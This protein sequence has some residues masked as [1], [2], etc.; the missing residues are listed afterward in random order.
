[1][2]MDFEIWASDSGNMLLS[3]PD[4]DEA[5]AW[6]LSYWRRYGNEAFSALS[7]GDEQNQW[8]VSG[9]DLRNLLWT[10]LW[11]VRAPWVTSASDRV[12]NVRVRAPWVTSASDR[13]VNI[14]ELQPIPVV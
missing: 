11:R 14:P 13:V 12:V 4:L 10:R 2:N 3:T 7:I 1:M 6:A 8:A 9:R 5:L